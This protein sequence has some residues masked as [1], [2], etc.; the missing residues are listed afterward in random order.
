MLK[1]HEFTRLRFLNIVPVSVEDIMIKTAITIGVCGRKARFIFIDIT[2]YEL[3]EPVL[4][5][6]LST[7]SHHMWCLWKSSQFENAFWVKLYEKTLITSIKMVSEVKGKN[8]NASLG[9]HLMRLAIKFAMFTHVIKVIWKIRA[10]DE[11]E[12]NENKKSFFGLHKN[13][14]IRGLTEIKL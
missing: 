14:Q 2:K 13:V 5:S 11:K 7:K 10:C 1:L 4:Q 12:M 6:F 8:M 3:K 9:L